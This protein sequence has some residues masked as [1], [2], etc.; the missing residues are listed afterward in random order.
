MG[1]RL[2]EW[3]HRYGSSATRRKEYVARGVK[4]FGGIGVAE[5]EMESGSLSVGDEVVITGPT[6]GAVFVTIEEIRVNLRPVETTV[7]SERF[8]IRTEEKV[9]ASNRMYKMVRVTM[10]S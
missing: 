9:R 1:Q 5:F 10:D 7:K 4:Y 3:T 2:G 8:S 6:T